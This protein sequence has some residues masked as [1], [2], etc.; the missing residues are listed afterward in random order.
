MNSQRR[1]RPHVLALRLSD[2]E[3]RRVL[4]GRPPGMSV[5]AYVLFRLDL[6]RILVKELARE[7]QRRRRDREAQRAVDGLALMR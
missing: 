2:D 5:R 3:R 4:D 1:R 7:E 6:A